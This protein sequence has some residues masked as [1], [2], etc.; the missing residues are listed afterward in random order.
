[1][2]N[3]QTWLAMVARARAVYECAKELCF[4]ILAEVGD[5]DL[6]RMAQAYWLEC[7]AVYEST[8]VDRVAI[9]QPDCY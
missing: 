7:Y 4:A 9:P 5:T 6:Y 1:M 2:D 8:L 3:Y